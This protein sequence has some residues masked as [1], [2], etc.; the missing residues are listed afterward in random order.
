MQI[1]QLQRRRLE[2]LDLAA[3]QL[4]VIPANQSRHYN[5]SIKIAASSLKDVRNVV[6]MI[7]DRLSFAVSRS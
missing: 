3:T 7:D 6:V 5:I 4:F 1:H 2:R